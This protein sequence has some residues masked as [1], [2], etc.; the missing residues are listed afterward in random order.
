MKTRREES[1]VRSGLSR[2]GSAAKACGLK[3]LCSYKLTTMLKF[4]LLMYMSE[5]D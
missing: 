1:C 2:L 5:F 3:V 4:A